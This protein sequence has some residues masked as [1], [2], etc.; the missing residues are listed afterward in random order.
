MVMT[1]VGQMNNE[2]AAQAYRLAGRTAD[3]LVTAGK[4]AAADRNATW[5]KMVARDLTR[6]HLQVPKAVAAQAGLSNVAT[7][8]TAAAR[9]ANGAGTAVARAGAAQAASGVFRGAVPLTAALFVAEGARTAYKYARGDIDGAEAGRRVA[10]SAGS[11]SGGLG[12]A[13]AGA[14][15][16]SAIAPGVGT[17][18]GSIL[19]GIGGA[20]GLRS[21]VR[22]LTH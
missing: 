4:I 12:G 3:A 2:L 8:G 9:G 5:A 10:E 1:T 18:I 7:A 11:A 21:L 14:A 19:G 17:L 13:M 15:I 22:K 20:S 6:Y 16:G